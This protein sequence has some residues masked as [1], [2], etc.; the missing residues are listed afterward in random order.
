MDID[1]QKSIF[2]L[3]V[4]GGGDRFEVQSIRSGEFSSQIDEFY[5]LIPLHLSSFTPSF[6]ECYFLVVFMRLPIFVLKVL[7]LL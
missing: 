7:Y 1:F 3:C 6:L 2:F 5:L 4:G